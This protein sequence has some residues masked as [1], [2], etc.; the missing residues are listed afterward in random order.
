[1]K[2]FHIILLVFLFLFK[3]S[4][5]AQNL[6]RLG[7]VSSMENDSLLYA[8]GFRLIGTAVGSLISP[9]IPEKDF[10]EN[11][12]RVKEASCQLY[13]CNIL[14]PSK[15]KI[16]GPDVEEE[17]VLD[18]FKVV[19]FRAREAGVNNLI[20]GSGGSRRLPEGYDVKKAKKDFIAL[21]KKLAVAA[22]EKGVTIILESLNSTETNFLNTLKE[23][24]EIVRKVNHPNFRLNADIYHM[25]KENESPQE[26]IN[27]GKLIVYCEI[28]EKENR[29][30]PGV[31][32]EDFR[33]YF[34]ALKKINFSGPILIEGRSED[35]K[36]DV[37]NAYL[38]LMNQLKEVYENPK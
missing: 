33:P 2:P 24:A 3:L 35:L 13:M 22:Q 19:L 26:I 15:L 8:S 14:F 10:L 29:T 37:P 30:L 9:S 34:K 25:M 32:G 12:K 17:Q 7:M 11:I 4:T 5:N 21:S 31:A 18:Y 6:P 38:Y 23:A 20:L 1:M 27:A 36:K 16:A 28:A